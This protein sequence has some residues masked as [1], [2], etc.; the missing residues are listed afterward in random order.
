M[1][2]FLLLMLCFIFIFSPV[3]S[4]LAWAETAVDIANQMGYSVDPFYQPKGGS[5][6]VDAATGQILWAEDYD[7][8]WVPASLTKLMVL[9]L[10]YQAIDRGDFNE[11]TMVTVTPDISELSTYYSLSNN[12]MPVDAQYSVAE[13]IDL[14][15][16]PSSAAGTM[17]L[18][19]QMGLTHA[20]IVEQM[21]Q[22]AKDLGMKQTHYYN[23]IGAPN[24]ILGPFLPEGMP[25]DGDNRSSAY[26][27]A[28][29]ATHIVKEYPQV[30]D[31]TSKLS[32][33]IRPGTPLED[34]FT[35]Y[36][37]SLQGGMYGLEGLD[38]I[39][40]GSSGPAAFNFT[41][42][43]QRGDTRLVE[44]VLGVGDWTMKESEYVRSMIGNSLLE[45][46]F[47][48]YEYR[49]VLPKGEHQLDGQSILTEEDFYDIV[50]INQEVEFQLTKPGFL[51][52][53]GSLSVALDRT[54][55]H[56]Y[57]APS[58]NYQLISPI[59][60]PVETVTEAPQPPQLPQTT[61]LPMEEKQVKRGIL[62]ISFYLAALLIPLFI[63]RALILRRVRNRLKRDQ[64]K[65]RR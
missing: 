60:E 50:P 37:Y 9:Y 31:H 33:V 28:I 38:G 43:A 15:I 22:T 51:Q 4:S 41:T 14:V 65:W 49:L 26:D 11:Q 35:T 29:L 44:V 17:L 48:E 52:K 18:I 5:I 32:T 13:L 54:Y 23:A 20:Q 34:S 55:L 64:R 36:N 62:T 42:T 53:T 21:N 61:D 47:Q 16:M 58:I 12:W 24:A 57:T 40:T 1:K 63:I 3:L 6:V 30:L 45:K 27:Y 10:A 8:P 39:K 19:H 7:T 46:V 2:R 56:G 59:Q 25:L